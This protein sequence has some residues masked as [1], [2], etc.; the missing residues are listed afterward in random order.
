MSTNEPIWLAVARKDV[1]LAE[2][3]GKEHSPVIQRWLK[4]LGA[5]WTDDETP[6]CGT[7]VAHWMRETGMPL[8]RHWYR[9]KGWLDWGVVLEHPL[10]GCVVVFEREGGGHV[11]LVVGQDQ[12]GNLMC[13]GGNQGNRVTIAPFKRQRVAGYRWP[14]GEVFYDAELP[15][16]QSFGGTSTQEA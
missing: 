12:N 14:K 10:V 1:G 7:A 4:S 15:T 6:W 8:P 2:I 16:V 9:A 11:A 3:P 13:L 5:W